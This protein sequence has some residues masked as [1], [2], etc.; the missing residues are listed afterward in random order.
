MKIP[1][2]LQVILGLTLLA[3]VYVFWQ[4]WFGQGATV[5]PV[6]DERP[7]RTRAANRQPGGQPNGP[8]RF[9][10]RAARAPSGEY[11]KDLSSSSREASAARAQSASGGEQEAPA[12]LKDHAGAI[13][14]AGGA[15]GTDAPPAV[16]L[17]AAQSW[18]SRPPETASAA[19]LPASA[20]TGQRASPSPPSSSFANPFRVTAEWRVPGQKSI[21]VIQGEGQSYVLCDAC[22][23]PG[24]IRPHQTFGSGY[25]LDEIGSQ[26]VTLT[27]LPLKRRTV[28]PL[29]TSSPAK[30]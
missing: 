11:A 16:N 8:A 21:V 13:S 9:A 18:A 5:G 22:D 19:S 2:Y 10:A 17:F 30:D 6:P 7:V 25:R 4:D 26:Q 27:K 15:S 3:C 1:R 12:L 14:Q 28:L 24:H 23:V 29:T 20:D